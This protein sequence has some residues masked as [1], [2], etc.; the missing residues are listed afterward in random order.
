MK[1]T[2]QPTIKHTL[3]CGF[4][5]FAFSAAL[6]AAPALDAVEASV[7]AMAGAAGA[8]VNVRRSAVT[9][10]VT[11]ISTR[12]QQPIVLNVPSLAPASERA[13][14]FMAAHGQAFGITT[15]RQVRV[16]RVTKKDEV[17]MD[18]VRLQQLHQ[19]IP[20]TAGELTVHLRGASVVSVLAKTLPDPTEV[21]IT[22]EIGA[23]EAGAIVSKLLREKR[24]IEDAEIST[25]RLEILNKGLL[26]GV[27]FPSRLAWFLVASKVD[28]R[29]YFWVDAKRGA[30]LLNFSQ[31]PDA[32]NRQIHDAASSNALPGTLVRSEG[33]APIGDPDADRAYDFSGDTY[34]YFVNEHGRDSFDG[35]GAAILSTA[36]F[37]PSPAQCPFQNAFWNGVQM[38]YGEGFSLADDVDAHELTHAV[39]EFSAN[40]F[41]YMQSGALNESFSDIFGETVDLT[42][43]GGTDTPAVRW[44]VGED[45]P[46]FGAIRNM[47]NPNAFGDPGKV[48][49][50]QFKCV[51]FINDQG[52]VHSNSGVPNHAYALMVDGGAFNGRTV[53]GIGLTKAGKI[54]YRTLT[55]YLTTGSNFL[56][57]YRS[58]QQACSD[59]IGTA[60]ITPADC[61]AVKDAL[62]AVEM[63]QAICAIPGEPELCPA[64]QTR[65]DLFFDG[66]EAGGGNFVTQTAAGS[67]SW[68]LGSFFAKTGVFHLDNAPGGGIT[69]S[70]V[71]MNLDVPIPAGGAR[72][73]FSHVWEFEEFFSTFFDGAVVEFSTNGGASWNDAGSLIIAGAPYNGTLSSCCGNPL[74]GRAAFVGESFGYTATQLNLTSLAGQNARFRFRFGADSIV[75][76]VGSD[77]DDVRIYRCVSAP[78]PPPPPP[79]NP[80]TCNGLPATI[81]GTSVADALTGTPGD[82][83]IHGLGGND[84]IRG[85]GGN[86][87]ICGGSGKDRLFGG[88]GGDRLFGE[89][90]RDVLNGGGGRDRCNGGSGADTANKCERRTSVP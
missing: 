5:V 39:T 19:G 9:H 58:L 80:V 33:Q 83:V 74:G 6:H 47:M 62:D 88:P 87:V 54:Q 86:D 40:L 69:D 15:P 28:L 45:L 29:E 89:A 21:E 61:G 51:P 31:R 84:V 72:M 42:N 34:D 48:S 73:Q 11:F 46:G 7:E 4:L 49:D 57:N 53:T 8:P 65:T 41:Y 70:S 77:V 32:R 79:P 60:G 30:I 37:C 63:P 59:L 50:T 23:S 20:V 10:L 25:P 43:T 76:S 13:L 1:Q 66:L 85:N 12:P 56:D 52:G 16:M 2:P 78:P 71:A 81:V 18:H 68:F 90:D 35:L 26:E 17:G 24:F 22:P 3:Y 38:V 67:N 44:L 64:G 82:D 27:S 55:S 75:A 14:A 36:H